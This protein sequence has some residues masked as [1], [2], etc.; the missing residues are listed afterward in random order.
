MTRILDRLSGIGD[1]TIAIDS[2]NYETAER[3]SREFSD[4]L[5]L[6]LDDLGLG[7]G[8]GEPVALSSP[9]EVLRR[10]LPRLSELARAHSES[11]EREWAEAQTLKERNRLVTEACASVLAELEQ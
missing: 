1:I 7:N 4:D 3:L 6:L 10:V 2:E 9:P 8:N 11:L 5:R